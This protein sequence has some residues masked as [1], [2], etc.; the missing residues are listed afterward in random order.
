MDKRYKE[1]IPRINKG[2]G[3]VNMMEKETIRGGS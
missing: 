3:I 2:K 1:E